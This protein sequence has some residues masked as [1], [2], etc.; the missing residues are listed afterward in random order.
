MKYLEALTR[1]HV[2]EAIQTGLKSQS[3]QRAMT[4]QTE[5]APPPIPLEVSSQGHSRPSSWVYRIRLIYH[6]IRN[7]GE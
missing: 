7:P 2:N 1:L 4:G 6:H 5:P 3:N